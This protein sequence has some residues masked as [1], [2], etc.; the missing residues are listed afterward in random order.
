MQLSRHKKHQQYLTLGIQDLQQVSCQL[1]LYCRLD[2]E[3]I[4][5]NKTNKINGVG[6]RKEKLTGYQRVARG[7][8]GKLAETN[9]AVLRNE[10]RKK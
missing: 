3:K 9:L 7:L 4:E 8:Q 2:K 6:Y 10:T 5:N 1:Q